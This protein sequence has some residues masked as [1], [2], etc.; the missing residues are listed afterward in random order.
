MEPSQFFFRRRQGRIDWR[1]V[2]GLVSWHARAT[3]S[4]TLRASVCVELSDPDAQDIQ[5]IVRNVD[6]QAL[7]DCLENVTFSDVDAEGMYSELPLTECH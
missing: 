6:F 5:K 3:L 2:S 4:I 1:V 7:Q